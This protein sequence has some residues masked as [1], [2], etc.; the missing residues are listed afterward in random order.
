MTTIGQPNQGGPRYQHPLW[1]SVSLVLHPSK[2][3][4]LEEK[5]SRICNECRVTVIGLGQ[6]NFEV[7]K[8]Q[9][10]GWTLL[11]IR[12]L[13]GN[14]TLNSKPQCQDV[15]VDLF[16]DTLIPGSCCKF[17]VERIKPT[18]LQ[19]KTLSGCPSHRWRSALVLGAVCQ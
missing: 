13:I 5:T 6:A 19:K 11:D 2:R 10:S 17:M 1:V 7:T 12:I 4:H 9:T 18:G 3:T 15:V 14:G 8:M 16:V